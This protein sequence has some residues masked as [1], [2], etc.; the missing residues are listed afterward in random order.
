MCPLIRVSKV[1]FPPGSQSQASP[2]AH[3]LD[4]S[5]LK[6]EELVQTANCMFLQPLN[7]VAVSIQDVMV[8]L[9]WQITAEYWRGFASFRIKI[10]DT[11]LTSDKLA[12][13]NAESDASNTF[14]G[15]FV[16]MY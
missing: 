13:R 14:L 12:Y 8:I 5:P 2:F 15:G 6:I 1:Q 16:W 9:K 10:L 11:E 3:I 4:L 7:H